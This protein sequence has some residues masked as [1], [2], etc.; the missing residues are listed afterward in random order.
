[1]YSQYI[2]KMCSWGGGWWGVLNCDVDHI[3]QKFY[4]PFLT[5]F[6]TYKIISPPQTKMTSKDDIKGLVSLKFLR[7]WMLGS[8]PG[9]LRL[10]LWQRMSVA[11]PARLDLIHNLARSHPQILVTRGR[12]S[13]GVLCLPRNIYRRQCVHKSLHFEFLMWLPS[14][15]SRICVL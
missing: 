6:R 2:Q 10:T 5:R 12:W 1:M 9:L 15:C 7:P 11:L 8:I 3:L 13:L 4:T 14:L